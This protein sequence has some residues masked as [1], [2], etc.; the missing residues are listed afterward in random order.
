MIKAITDSLRRYFV[1]GVLIVAPVILTYVVLNF[2]F[3]SIDGILSPYLHKVLGYSVPGLGILTTLLLILLAGVL[4]YNFIGSRLFRAG[5]RMMRSFPFVRVI[6]LSAKQLV[7]GVTLPQ[8]KTFK[9]VALI[10]YP[11]RGVYAMCFVVK[12]P[13]LLRDGQECELVSLFVPS[14]PTPISGM[15]ILARPEEVTILELTVEEAFKFLVSGGIVSPEQ[16]RGRIL[17]PES[18]ERERNESD[19]TEN[20]IESNMRGGA[21]DA[22]GDTA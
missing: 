8:R 20:L 6:Y 3:K 5:D 9:E 10:E 19:S 21:D 11:R 4:T 2:L 18:R 7:E 15:V 12:R 1:A 13:R 22:S 17:Q 16:F 14:T